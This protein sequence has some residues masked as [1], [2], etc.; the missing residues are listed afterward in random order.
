[1][2]EGIIR[3]IAVRLGQWP[4]LVLFNVPLTIVIYCVCRS[5]TWPLPMMSHHVQN[6]SHCQDECQH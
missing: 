6:S 1:M 3:P 4:L 2:G 5:V